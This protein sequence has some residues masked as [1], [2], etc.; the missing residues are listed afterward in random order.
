MT[1]EESRQ[2][3]HDWLESALEEEQP[4]GSIPGH[5]LR[6]GESCDDCRARIEAAMIAAGHR[7]PPVPPA[8]LA[9]R[10]KEGLRTHAESRDRGRFAPAGDASEDDD[11]TRA[12][13]TA[14]GRQKSRVMRFAASA[15]V[16]A[17]AVLGGVLIGR[18]LPDSPAGPIAQHGERA[19]D[20]AGAETEPPTVVRVEFRLEAPQASE[21]AVVG[22]W[23]GWDANVNPLRDSDGDGVWETTVTLRPGEEYQYQFL[24]DDETWI[25]DPSSP[26]RVD[27]GFGGTNS[28]LNI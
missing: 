22:D 11:S 13:G 26:L 20:S 24:V 21:V 7:A 9:D 6:H 23:N 27:D 14:A 1:C 15:A 28:V 10:V 17:I 18:S 16:L 19:D 4:L 25:P 8:D 2:Q 5:I 12:R 3:L